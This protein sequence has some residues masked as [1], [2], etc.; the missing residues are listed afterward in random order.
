M[1]K[2]D[3]VPDAALSTWD[4]IEIQPVFCNDNGNCEVCDE[5]QESFWS[6]YLH[7]VG[8]GVQCVADLPTQE[9][10]EK[11]ASLLKNASDYRLIEIG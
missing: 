2:L 10:A 9:L 6:V 5:G 3:F 11:L 1:E 4:D 8:G 7:Q